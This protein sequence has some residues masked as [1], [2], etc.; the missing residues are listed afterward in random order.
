[1]WRLR[2]VLAGV[3]A[4]SLTTS[5]PSTVAGAW[6]HFQD[7][8]VLA[9]K[10]G[11]A[12]SSGFAH[13]SHL[14]VACCTWRLLCPKVWEVLLWKMNLVELCVRVLQRVNQA[15]LHQSLILTSAVTGQNEAQT[16][17]VGTGYLSLSLPHL[18]NNPSF[19]SC[20]WLIHTPPLCITIGFP[21]PT[22][23]QCVSHCFLYSWLSFCLQSFS[24]SLFTALLSSSWNK[25]LIPVCQGWMTDCS[26]GERFSVST[27]LIFSQLSSASVHLLSFFSRFFCVSILVLFFD[28]LKPSCRILS[29]CF[30]TTVQYKPQYQCCRV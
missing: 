4:V 15:Y 17:W 8:S 20:A 29:F 14:E 21:L 28:I 30:C 26:R 12:G 23:Q 1:M 3:L 9:E 2:F 13:L 6:E 24:L 25:W 19:S 11:K 5:P 16:G 18:S 27:S 7:S 22:L 10:L